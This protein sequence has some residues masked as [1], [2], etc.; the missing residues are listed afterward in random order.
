MSIATRAAITTTVFLSALLVLHSATYGQE[1]TPAQSSPEKQ[2]M[3]A[4][5][6]ATPDAASPA[7]APVPAPDFW[8]QE[9]M[10]GDW[11]GARSRM[12]EKGVTTEITLSQFAQG[13]AA[14][15]ITRG[16]VYNG[17]FQTDFKF[18]FGK[19]AGWQFWSADFKTET[20]Y[21]GPVLLG[22]GSI[23]PVNTI[24][25][26]PAASGTVFSITT[27]N[28]TKLFPIDLKKGNLLAVSVGR[29]NL[30]DLIEEDFFA[31]GGIERFLNIAQI[32]PLT[33]LRQ[34]PLITN[35]AT[36]AY[37]RRGEPFITFALL[38]PNDHSTTTGL[39][40]LFAD[41]VTLSPA[42]NFPTKF[43]GKT[44]KS[45][46]GVAVTT[47]AYTP[48]DAIRQVI[49]PGPPIRPITPQRGSWSASYT[50]RQYIVERAP[51]NGWGVFSQL[52]FADNG[53]SPIATF[54]DIGLGGNGIFK[55]RLRDEFGISYAFTDLSS[56]LKDNLSLL[57]INRPQP[58]HQM[59][60]F[61]NFHITPWL[62]LTADLQVIR[63]TRSVAQTAVVPGGRLE[64]VF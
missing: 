50:A 21:G 59:E 22:V 37:V 7:P 61:Y 33:V 30:L 36:V 41:G 62:R 23:N 24:T 53:T 64:M 56:V 57:R 28:V 49:I 58:E 20:R 35:A 9:E 17:S 43:F 60:T 27:L 34:V 45:T 14:G 44:G 52:S 39:S 3:A 10:T 38:D 12:K 40:D 25:I 15:G 11:G 16:G 29:Y 5:T 42:I 13:V 6:P 26:V 54:F 48:F 2:K 63:P 18:D 19:L 46:F 4:A 51:H 32:G 1:P 47:K 55:S 31:G 8:E